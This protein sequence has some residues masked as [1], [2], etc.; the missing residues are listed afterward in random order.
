MGVG[1]DLVPP[2]QVAEQADRRARRFEQGPLDGIAI[3]QLGQPVADGVG[4]G[5]VT[6]QKRVAEEIGAAV[7]K[8]RDAFE[9]QIPAKARRIEHVSVEPGAAR[10]R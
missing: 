8:G 4:G 7:D 5:N 10:R 3:E 9:H 2:G 1:V 6:L